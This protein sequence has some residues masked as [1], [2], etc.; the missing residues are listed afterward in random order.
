MTSTEEIRRCFP[1]LARTHNDY[2]VAYFDGPGGT[3]VPR[4][5]VEA[6]SDYLYH[7]NAN[8]HW[9]YPTSEETDVIIE[10]ARSGLADFL[11]ASPSEIVF[12]A[13]MTTLTFHLAHALGRGYEPDDEI[14]VTELDHHANV[15]PWR[16]LEKE[17]GV[18]V[19]TVKMIPETGEL[20][21]DDFSMLLNERT[22][23]VAIG[24]ASNALGTIN[25]VP[26]VSE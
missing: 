24:A 7:H 16:A 12:G 15:A 13:N 25:D 2:P 23:L 26:R 21:W 3:Q 18:K 8:T 11:N 22:K 19:R 1:A 5:V 9:A 14:V 17:R 10:F 6:M 4:T 20:D